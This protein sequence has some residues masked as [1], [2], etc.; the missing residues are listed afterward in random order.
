[1]SL[2]KENA[3][4]HHRNGKRKK[5]IYSGGSCLAIPPR[6]LLPKSDHTYHHCFVS[7]TYLGPPIS[8]KRSNLGTDVL[9]AKTYLR[10]EPLLHYV[11]IDIR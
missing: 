1:V 11:F 10:K 9:Y 8:D 4:A 3:T 2:E 6:P 5:K 7:N